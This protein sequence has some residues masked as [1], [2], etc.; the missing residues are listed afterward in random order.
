MI[1]F[2]WIFVLQHND[3]TGTKNKDIVHNNT[4]EKTI[5]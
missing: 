3:Q 5:I 1:Y 2:A 4:R